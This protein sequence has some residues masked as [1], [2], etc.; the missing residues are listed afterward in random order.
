[1][2]GLEFDFQK[3]R[4]S[5]HDNLNGFLS[6]WIKNQNGIK[7]FELSRDVIVVL[8]KILDEIS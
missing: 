8:E 1:M 4:E 7:H 2:N 5:L 6:E 3:R